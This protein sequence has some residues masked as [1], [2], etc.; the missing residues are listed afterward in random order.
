M[1]LRL[2]VFIMTTTTILSF[3]TKAELD[4]SAYT[5]I[6]IREGHEARF[7]PLLPMDEIRY[8]LNDSGFDHFSRVD[9]IRLT[10]HVWTEDGTAKAG[11]DYLALEEKNRHKFIW[12]NQ[13]LAQSR[14]H[15]EDH[16]RLVDYPDNWNGL[17]TYINDEDRDKYPNGSKK[18]FYVVLA[19][20]WLEMTGRECTKWNIF[21]FNTCDNWRHRSSHNH[22]WNWDLLASHN[23]PRVIKFVV[24][25]EQH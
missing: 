10:Y 11:K 8:R 5:S 15:W 3:S 7:R 17:R 21:I 2:F 25:I 9:H 12:T 1:N 16:L 6:T 18:Y 24:Y 14:D 23:T 19:Y 4:S 22:P 20:P 13:P